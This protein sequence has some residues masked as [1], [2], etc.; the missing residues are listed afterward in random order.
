MLG[1]TVV[2]VVVDGRAVVGAKVEGLAVGLAVGFTLD[3]LVGM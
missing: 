1:A 3:K 2:G